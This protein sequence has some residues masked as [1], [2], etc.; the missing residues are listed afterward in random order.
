M[1]YL[2][3]LLV[4]LRQ[5]IWTLFAIRKIS[6][7]GKGLKCNHKCVFNRCTYLGNNCNFN[8]MIVYGTGK[9]SIGDNFHS[10]TNCQ[11]I[12]SFHN[13]DTGTMIPYDETFI[14]KPVV[15]GNNVWLGNNVIILGGTTIGDGAIIQAGSVLCGG[16]IPSLGIAGGHPAKVFKYRNKE[17]YDMLVSQGHT[18]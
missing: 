18:H 10:G 8:G 3:R 17:H 5:R 13:Y 6:K 2:V 9:V 16:V 4:Y 7:H 12:T 1:R 14:T 11:I 15:I